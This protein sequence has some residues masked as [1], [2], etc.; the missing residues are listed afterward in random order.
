MGVG[1]FAPD[2]APVPVFREMP[3][4]LP[5]VRLCPESGDS[6]GAQT[7]ILGLPKGWGTR[8]GPVF[9][10]LNVSVPSI[11]CGERLGG[12]DPLS[13]PP[14]SIHTL[15]PFETSSTLCSAVAGLLDL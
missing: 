10:K 13:P 9:E 3:E 7:A 2:Q 5:S 14:N 12:L 11:G 4:E 8:C 6:P 15:R 1:G